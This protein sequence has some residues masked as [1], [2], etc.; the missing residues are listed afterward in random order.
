MNLAAVSF[1]ACHMVIGIPG[2]II[3]LYIFL[4]RFQASPFNL[5]VSV[6]AIS[7]LLVCVF[8]MPADLFVSA[9]PLSIVAHS[10]LCKALSF[11]IGLATFV[12]SIIFVAIAYFRYRFICYPHGRP[13]RL[14][15]AKIATVLAVI[16]AGISNCLAPV[17]FGSRPARN[18]GK[19]QQL[20][21]GVTKQAEGFYA[22][23]F[24]SIVFVLVSTMTSALVYWYMQVGKALWRR[25]RIT[26]FLVESSSRAT[27]S[28]TRVTVSRS[29]TSQTGSL[30]TNNLVVTE[31]TGRGHTGVHDTNPKTKEI[32]TINPDT[33]CIEYFPEQNPNPKHRSQRI[34]SPVS[35]ATDSVTEPVAPERSDDSSLNVTQAV[36]GTSLLTFSTLPRRKRT[37]PDGTMTRSQMVRLKQTVRAVLL[38]VVANAVFLASYVPH[39]AVMTVYAV[40]RL[41]NYEHALGTVIFSICI[42]SPYFSNV[43]NPFIYGF[44]SGEFRKELHFIVSKVCGIR[45]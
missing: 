40:F 29:E 36:S 39:A 25:T 23:L 27:V 1:T 3:V 6:L 45:H 5:L 42:R 24:Y 32:R 8:I 9:N 21:C 16:L 12:S 31:Q 20:E 11:F 17:T 33:T 38:V 13:V 34:R 7:D 28:T 41:G 26:P 37:V 35:T 22:I 14:I 4:F 15:D 43:C 2:N 18:G 19:V 44:G 30:L 10:A